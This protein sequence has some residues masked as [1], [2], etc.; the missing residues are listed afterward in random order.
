MSDPPGV[1]DPGV[2]PAASANLLAFIGLLD[3]GDGAD[4]DGRDHSQTPG[5]LPRIIQRLGTE[6]DRF[7]PLPSP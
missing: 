7:T 3:G 5:E 6:R 1:V 2:S 4:P